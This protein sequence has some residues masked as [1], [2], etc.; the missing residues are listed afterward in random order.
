MC[1]S[2]LKLGTLMMHTLSFGMVLLDQLVPLIM[3]CRIGSSA[4][5]FRRKY[6]SARPPTSC[7]LA[8]YAGTLILPTV[9]KSL[10]LMIRPIVLLRWWIDMPVLQM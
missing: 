7:Q 4:N 9:M 1:P 2:S 5:L 3:Q 10:A 8:W 6:A